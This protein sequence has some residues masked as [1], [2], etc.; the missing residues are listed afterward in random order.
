MSNPY[1]DYYKNQIGGGISGF[2]GVKFQKG[3]G[4]RGFKGIRY[5][6]GHGFFGNLLSKAVYPFLK[7]LG[8]K[9]ANVGLNVASDIIV[10]KKNIKDSLQERLKEG[11]KDIAN[12]GLDRA[13][14]FIQTGKGRK[15]K[16]KIIKKSIKRKKLALERLMI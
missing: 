9:A 8:K 10:D 6:R 7:F 15:R 16:R 5:Q 13:K 14:E 1:I 11:G 12:A 4:I 2:K 3:Y